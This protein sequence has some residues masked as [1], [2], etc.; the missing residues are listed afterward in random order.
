MTKTQ[1]RY[2]ASSE[3]QMKGFKHSWIVLRQ[4]VCTSKGASG[5]K[6]IHERVR[7]FIRGETAAD[8]TDVIRSPWWEKS[9]GKASWSEN[10]NGS[11]NRDH[12][13]GEGRSMGTCAPYARREGFTPLTKTPK[14]ILAMD[15]VNF[16]PP[17]PMVGTSEKRNMNNGLMEIGSYGERYQAKRPKEQRLNQRKEKVISMVRSQGYRKR[18]YKRVEHG[19]DNTI[20][21]SSV[22]RYQLMDCPVVVDALIEGFRV[23]RIYVDG[24]SSSEI[25]YEHYFRN[26]SYRTRLRLRESRNPLVK[27]LGGVNYPLGVIDLEVTMGECGRTRTVIMEFAVKWSRFVTYNAL[28]GRTGMRSLGA[29]ASTIHSM[30]KFLT[31]NGIT[32]ITTTRETLRECRQIE[33]A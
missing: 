20:A 21:F 30:I 24:G 13:R 17:P 27:F 32:T 11:R 1:R 12:R 8:T 28:R 9:A 3:S 18:P 4:K 5:V 29:V 23:R 6:D 15:N 2:M 16:P 7:A 14:E 25:M 33:E 26:L 31:S 22:P 19:M 10:Q